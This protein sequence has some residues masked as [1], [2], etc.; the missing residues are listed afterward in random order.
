[1]EIN[2]DR[3]VRAFEENPVSFM[4]AAGAVLMGVSKLVEA[5]GNARGSNAY[6][7]DVN[8]RVRMSKKQYPKF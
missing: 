5:A 1:M 4:A 2:K 6:A 8:R 3:I 7:R